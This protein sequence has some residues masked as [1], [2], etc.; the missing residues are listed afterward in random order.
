MEGRKKGEKERGREG[1]KEK[2]NPRYNTYFLR[3]VKKYL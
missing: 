1:R 3:R 2:K